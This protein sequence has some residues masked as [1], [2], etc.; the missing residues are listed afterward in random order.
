LFAKYF[1]V[2][3]VAEIKYVLKTTGEGY[4]DK[5]GHLESVSASVFAHS[6]HGHTLVENDGVI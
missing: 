6:G 1:P 2:V 3:A 4:K 5:M